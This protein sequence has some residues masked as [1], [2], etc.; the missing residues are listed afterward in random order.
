MSENVEDAEIVGEEISPEEKRKTKGAIITGA[1][2][3]PDEEELHEQI[4]NKSAELIDLIQTAR[5]VPGF[6]SADRAQ[7][8]A[9]AIRQVE[10]GCMFAVKATFIKNEKI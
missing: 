6:L 9:Y 3:N 1:K 7:T 10:S 8:I 4:R 2:F 5:K